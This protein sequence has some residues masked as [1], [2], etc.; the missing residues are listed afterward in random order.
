VDVRAR[1]D[2]AGSGWTDDRRPGDSVLA[3]GRAVVWRGAAVKPLV[4]AVTRPS[5]EL[6]GKYGSPNLG[7]LARLR[8]LSVDRV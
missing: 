3:F 5:V 2:A 6:E 8:I 1:S 4:G 7:A